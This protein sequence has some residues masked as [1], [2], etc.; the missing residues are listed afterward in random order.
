MANTFNKVPVTVCMPIYNGALY[1]RDAIRSVLN[2]TVTPQEI[3][4]SDSGS[5]DGT[6]NIMRDEAEGTRVKLVVLATKT[7]G[8]VANWNS[9]IRAASGKYIKFLFQ[10]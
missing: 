7:P 2:Q 3:V 1:V 5:S 9:T 10:D 6:V 4:V 8:M